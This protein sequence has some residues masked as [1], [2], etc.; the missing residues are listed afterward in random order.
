MNNPAFLLPTKV[1]PLHLARKAVVYIRQSSPKQVREN[2]GSQLNQRALVDR[3]RE[4]GWPAE[5]IEVL[6]GDLGQSG[7]ATAGRQDFQAL[8]T[9]VAL[10]QVGI[11]LGWEVSRL[12]RYADRRCRG[13]VRSSDL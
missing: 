12:V 2:L 13:R 5:R 4:L 9:A 6:D 3:A 10:G 1:Q 7:A 11:V 8:T